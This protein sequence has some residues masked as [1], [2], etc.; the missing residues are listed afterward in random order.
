MPDE[1]L[2]FQN[3]KKNVKVIN[4][5]FAGYDTMLTQEESQFVNKKK[6]KQKNKIKND[7]RNEGDTEKSE[8]NLIK[9]KG[10]GFDKKFNENE[11]E[12]GIQK[13]EKAYNLVIPRFDPS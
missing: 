9:S 6:K 13:K 8:N 4:N 5:S 2:F 1:T 7:E 11:D 12:F 10:S 3:K